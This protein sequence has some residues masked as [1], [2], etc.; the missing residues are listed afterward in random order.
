MVA[1]ILVPV[2]ILTI[3]PYWWIGKQYLFLNRRKGSLGK[4][5]CHL[6]RR[7][8]RLLWWLPAM[9]VIG[10]SGF[11]ALE[12]NFLPDNPVL[13]DI[14]FGV[15]AMFAVPQF[16]FAFC[17]FIGWLCMRIAKSGKLGRFGFR[18]GNQGR[19]WGKLVGLVLAVCAFFTFI[20]GFT[21]GFPKMEVKQ[22]TVYVPDLPKQFDGYR[23][24][25][26]SDIHLGSYYG[27]RCGLP[28][29]DVDSINAQHAD[30]ICFTGDLQNV[31]PSELKPYIKLMQRLK[32]KDGVLSVLG[33]HDYTWY[34]NIDEDDKDEMEKIEAEVRQAEKNMGWR[35][36]NNE[37]IVIHR[38]NDS[39]Y[40]A[41][42]ENYE[43]PYRSDIGKALYGIK[44][45]SFVMMLQHMPKQWS[46]TLPS[47]IAGND[48]VK[49]APQ[50][51]L[52]GHTHAGQVSVL[53]VRPSMFTPFDYGLYEREGCQLYTTSGLGGTVPIRV[54][55][56]AEIAVIT[57]RCK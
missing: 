6:S 21:L 1:R 56:T 53:G 39:I 13:I 42:T 38:G 3:L 37:H 11:L 34:L 16:V 57:L 10:Y 20:Y 2:I 5:F 14:W 19:N 45:G 54:G 9:G 30:L 25:H 46:K 47:A 43:K 24:V 44:P 12:R 50:L 17:S 48:S 32:A 26:F 22:L 29:R 28:Q 23:I 33:N 55:A 27:W 52:S 8:L 15:M 51:T 35:L 49:V 40:V 41:G 7:W 36:L 18:P 4:S 31:Q